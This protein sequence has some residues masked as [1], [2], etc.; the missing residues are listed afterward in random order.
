MS[1]SAV[2]ISFLPLAQGEGAQPGGLS[3]LLGGMLPFIMIAILFY[4][5]MIRPERR[6]KA[7]L[8]EMLQ[9]LK[10]NTRVVTIGGIF[11]TVVSTSKDSE[12]VTLMID[13]SNSTKMRVQRNAI[14]RVI[15]GEKDSFAK[16]P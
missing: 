7:E 1:W 12:E 13:D 8:M 14:A 10:K 11:G 5:L 9:N 3:G 4:L 16:N 2:L 15:G 6:K